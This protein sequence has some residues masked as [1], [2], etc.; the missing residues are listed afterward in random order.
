MEGKEEKLSA[1]SV[2][3]VFVGKTL[4]RWDRSMSAQLL[5]GCSTRE[6]PRTPQRNCALERQTH[7]QI[8]WNPLDKHALVA[9]TGDG[10]NRR[11]G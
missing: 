7:L 2:G 6:L 10:I 11:R 9:C 4:E 8:S 1:P 3:F 5:R